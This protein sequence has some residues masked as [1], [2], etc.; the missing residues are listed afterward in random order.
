MRKTEIKTYL[1]TRNFDKANRTRIDYI[2]IHYTANNGDSAMSNARYFHAAYRAASAHYFVDSNEAV[3]VVLEKDIAW[4]CGDTQ[5]YIPPGGASYKGQCKN[6]NSIGVEMC[7]KVVDGKYIIPQ[8]IQENAVKLVDE[9]LGRYPRA[10]VIRHYDVTGKICPRPFI[11]HP[12][13]WETFLAGI[14]RKENDMT[15]A[16]TRKIVQEEIQKA[17]TGA[18]TQ[19]ADWA[20]EELH[21]AV[22]EGVT[23]GSR[24]SGYLQRQEG[25]VL[26][27]RMEKRILDHLSGKETLWD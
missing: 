6:T 4:H 21:Q 1:T 26:T 3:Q 23:D 5:K 22:K 9:L 19:P 25:I 27:M 12:E 18:N 2:V 15:E 8:E 13:Q 14:K 11:E 24:P 10:Q 17:L 16:D 20:V 7:S